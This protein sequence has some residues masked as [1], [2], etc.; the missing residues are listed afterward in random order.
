MNGHPKPGWKTS[1]FY[2]TLIGQALTLLT[3]L[4][5]VT[6]GDAA[7][8]QDSLS[9]CVAAIFIVAAN[10]A[11][12]ISYIRNRTDLK[13]LAH[14]GPAPDR[15]DDKPDGSHGFT[16][17]LPALL[18]GLAMGLVGSPV[19]AQQPRVQTACLPWRAQIERRLDLLAQQG[20][21]PQGDPELKELLR[22][23]IV[24]LQ[25]QQAAPPAAPQVLVIPPY[26]LLPI[27]G[28]PKQE[29]PIA[30]AP[31]QE[32]PIPGA[33]KQE[34]PI[35][36]A[37]KQE[38]PVPGTPKQELPAPGQPRQALPGEGKPLQPLPGGTKPSPT[39]YQRY[40]LY[41]LSTQR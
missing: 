34:L 12:V 36:G 32:L 30:G 10:A 35:P 28:Q 7:L 20:K 5:V 22:Q 9:K 1:E 26:Q 38:L 39:G 4:G 23:L 16:A 8:L 19:Q 25:H 37:P 33:P 3:L 41:R 17:I 11:L 40:T 27:Q 13:V 2:I 31:K 6:A 14:S 18:L 15:H 24:L 29:L 21:A